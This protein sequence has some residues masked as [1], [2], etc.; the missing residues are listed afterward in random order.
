MALVFI[1]VLPVP[2]SGSA[3]AQLVI[4]SSPPVW[5]RAIP[6]QSPEVGNGVT[7]SAPLRMEARR[8]FHVHSPIYTGLWSL[9]KGK[10]SINDSRDCAP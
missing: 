1:D 2:C 4:I 10:N 9:A 7:G 8:G 3:G 6:N 5:V